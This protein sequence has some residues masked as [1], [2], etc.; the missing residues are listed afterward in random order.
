M[1]LLNLLLQGSGVLVTGESLPTISN[2]RAWK[3]HVPH[4]RVEQGSLGVQEQPQFQ[5]LG[6]LH[7]NGQS[8]GWDWQAGPA[9]ASQGQGLMAQEVDM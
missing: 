7:G 2:G 1:S 4:S 6:H 8:P 5:A 3:S 9:V